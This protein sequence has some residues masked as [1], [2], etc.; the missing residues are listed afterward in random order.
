[1]YEAGVELYQSPTLKKLKVPYE[2]MSDR[3]IARG[4]GFKENDRITVP[5]ILSII[6]YT[7][8]TSL[9][10]D[11]SSSFRFL[12][13]SE[14]LRGLIKRNSKWYYLSKYLRE[15]VEIFGSRVGLDDQ[16]KDA[17]GFST[18][19]DKG[20]FYHSVSYLLFPSFNVHFYGPLSISK[21]LSVAMLFASN[22][23]LVIQLKSRTPYYDRQLRFFNVS[24]I[25]CFSS[26]DERLFIGGQFPLQIS[27]IRLLKNNINTGPL[28]HTLFVIHKMIK[29]EKLDFSKKEERVTALDTSIFKK[30]LSCSKD[31]PLYIKQ[32]WDEFK[33]R[34][35]KIEIDMWYM[36][37]YYILFVPLLF[38][39]HPKFKNV[40]LLNRITQIFP[41]VTYI[42]CKYVDQDL[43]TGKYSS[44]I[45]C[46][47]F[48][49]GVKNL[50][51]KINSNKKLKKIIID[52]HHNEIE[53]DLYDK[54]FEALQ[55][56]IG[57]GGH[58]LVL[59][60]E[61]YKV[62]CK[63]VVLKIWSIIRGKAPL[64]DAT[65]LEVP[66]LN[67]LISDSK[68]LPLY[69][70]QKWD[71]FKDRRQSIIINM[72]YM[73]CNYKL[74]MPLLFS[75]DPKCKNLLR[76]NRILKIFPNVTQIIC[77]KTDWDGDKGKY[78]NYSFSIV[79]SSFIFG[80]KGMLSK[81][82]QNK[83]NELKKII[84]IIK[85]YKHRIG[86]DCNLYVKEFDALGWEIQKE[87]KY[88][89]E[90]EITLTKMPGLSKK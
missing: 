50:L 32:I 7:N 4:Y 85:T 52:T 38:S 75:S 80:L 12:S 25:S 24:L 11:F 18:E 81:I 68:D 33:H 34:Q 21:Q 9:C 23:G 73:Y 6:L 65:S 36:Y 51:T 86:D 79:S 10:M 2:Y 53:C 39:S 44:A 17:Y 61:P 71:E 59:T 66:I 49:L 77:K 27:S 41:N 82:K 67:K 13:H 89:G 1:M 55:W 62:I 64:Y 70:K 57:K 54:Q 58:T 78:G 30:L 31:L 69:V 46:S 5:H 56:R 3:Q 76:F 29:G 19:V 28:I 8:F 88:Y 45:V 90:G 48:I 43:E 87:N 83:S 40:L 26:E 20:S 47:S 74:F 14:S 16:E 15:V 84:I 22:Q 72:E 60:R 42:I 37:E 35:K 63:D